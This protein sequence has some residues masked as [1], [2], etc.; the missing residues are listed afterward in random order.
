[1]SYFDNHPIP[2]PF[3]WHE[4]EGDVLPADQWI[5][6][7]GETEYVRCPR[8]KSREWRRFMM[9]R[10]RCDECGCESR[11]TTPAEDRRIGVRHD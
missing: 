9:G 3:S 2:P 8:C 1:M 5:T 6:D 7:D 10:L 4:G 11:P